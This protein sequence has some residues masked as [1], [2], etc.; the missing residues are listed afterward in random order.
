M[1]LLC[2]SQPVYCGFIHIII[3]LDTHLTLQC[4]Q[5]LQGP[6]EQQYYFAV[7]W[8]HIESKLDTALPSFSTDKGLFT[9]R[10]LNLLP[11]S[12]YHQTLCWTNSGGTMGF[13]CVCVEQFSWPH[14]NLQADQVHWDEFSRCCVKKNLFRNVR[15]HI[16]IYVSQ[17][18]HLSTGS[19][20]W[21]RPKL[22]HHT[23][24]NDKTNITDKIQE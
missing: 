22:K 18:H 16:Y 13:D 6:A 23:N 2:C 3:G 20:I 5:G 9:I 11:F 17:I 8:Q 19:W 14:S 24:I 12:K 10:Y 7:G 1:V 21:N 4:S 15:I